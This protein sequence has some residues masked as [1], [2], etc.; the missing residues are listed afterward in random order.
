MTQ[1]S[2]P[3]ALFVRSD[4]GSRESMLRERLIFGKA[5]DLLF[6]WLPSEL[7][8]SWK[9]SLS[10]PVSESAMPA[11]GGCCTCLDFDLPTFRLP[12]ELTRLWKGSLSADL[13]RTALPP[14]KNPL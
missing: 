6:L 12:P 7:S 1:K 4:S 13:C 11:S 8:P 10:V 2:S 5:F 14:S 3:W 9:W